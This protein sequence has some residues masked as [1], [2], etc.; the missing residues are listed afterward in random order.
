MKCSVRVMKARLLSEEQQLPTP[1]VKRVLAEALVEYITDNLP[2]EQVLPTPPTPTTVTTTRTPTTTTTTPTPP[3][4]TTTTPTP[5][6]TTTTPT[7]ATNTPRVGDSLEVWWN[8]EGQWDPCVI[9]HQREDIDKTTASLC[10]YDGEEKGRWHNLHTERYRPLPPTKERLLKLSNRALRARLRED[11]IQAPRRL[12]KEQL[13]ELLLVVYRN[14]RASSW[15][16]DN[17][18]SADS[19]HGDTAANSTDSD[20]ADTADNAASAVCAHAD[21]AT[22]SADSDHADTADN[23]A[24][25]V[26]AHAD[27]TDNSADSVHADSA[28][29]SCTKRRT[30]D[31]TSPG[32]S[33]SHT[34]SQIHPHTFA[35]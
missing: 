7:T 11:E 26:C 15:L 35:H 21:T 30:S 18:A 29:S 23:A 31:H 27:T 33:P 24:S 1:R 5:T 16:A 34:R 25:A 14:N 4:A 17:V 9:K 13:V 6:T 19:G 20:Q 12:G 8:Y 32:H 10:H 22:N 2:L 3:T 28:D